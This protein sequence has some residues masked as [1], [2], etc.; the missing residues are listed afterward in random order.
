MED[1]VTIKPIKDQFQT[2]IKYLRSSQYA[3]SQLNL[4]KR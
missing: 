1:I 4:T 2:C 3:H